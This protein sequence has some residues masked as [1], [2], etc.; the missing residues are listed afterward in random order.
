MKHT[1]DKK[2][3]R[4]R[5]RASYLL[6]QQLYDF[7]TKKPS[8]VD[9]L[10][11]FHDILDARRSFGSIRNSAYAAESLDLVLKDNKEMNK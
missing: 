1:V 4:I 5:N 9:I 7:L 2:V 8:V 6:F 10:R 3:E 11:K